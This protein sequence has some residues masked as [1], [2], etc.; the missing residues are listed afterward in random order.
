MKRPPTSHAR[1]QSSMEYLVVCGALALAIGLGMS[2]PDSVLW[3]LLQAFGTAF[4]KFSYAISL[5]G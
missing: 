1:G 4:R 5:P 3:Q 2:G